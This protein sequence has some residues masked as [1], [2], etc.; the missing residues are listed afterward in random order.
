[1]SDQPCLNT[2]DE[3]R[4][5]PHFLRRVFKHL[6]PYDPGAYALSDI[7]EIFELLEAESGRRRAIF[8]YTGQMIRSIPSA[9][10]NTVYWGTLMIKHYFI[11]A[12][13]NFKRNRLTTALN[14]AGLSAAVGAAIVMYLFID[15]QLNMDEFHENVDDIYL[16]EYDVS[17][18]DDIQT[19][20]NS[21]LP[22]GPA[23]AASDPRVLDAVRLSSAPAA[24]RYSDTIHDE[25]IRFT[26]PEFFDVFSFPVIAG[27]ESSFRRGTGIV[28][29]EAIAIKYFGTQAAV[30]EDMY[31]TLSDGT[32]VSTTVSAVV[33]DVP[34]SSSFRFTILAPINMMTEVGVDFTD[35]ASFASAT[36]LHLAPGTDPVDVDISLQS[37]LQPMQLA[38]IDRTFERLTIEPLKEVPVRTGRLR[39]SPL[40]SMLP[41]AYVF[42]GILA[43]LVLLV[44]CFNYVNIAIATA[45][46]RS[47][48]IGIRKSVGSYRTQLIAQFLGENILLS[49]GALFVGVLLAEW[50][51]IPWLNSTQDGLSF[52][53]NYAENISLWVF[54]AMMLVITGLGAGMYPA[55][56]VSRFQPSEVLRG[57]T[58]ATNKRRM[59]RFMLSSQLIVSFMLLAFGSAMMRNAQHQKEID[60]GYGKEDRIIVPFG[61]S[62]GLKAFR[63]VIQ[64][65]ADIV[66]LASS[67]EHVGRGAQPAIFMFEAVEYEAEQL[68]IGYNYLKTMNI[69]LKEGRDFNNQ[70]GLDE[71]RSILINGAL[72]RQLELPESSSPVGLT[73]Q[74]ENED[75]EII[76]VTEDFY[77]AEFVFGIPPL[78][79]RI[80]PDESHRFLAIQTVPGMAAGT[81]SELQAVWK[82]TSPEL[83]FNAFYQDTVFDGYFAG[84]DSSAQIFLFIAF[85][86]LL[87]S[88]MGLF[89]LVLATVARRSVEIGVRKALG[90]SVWDIIAAMQKETARVALIALVIGAPLSYFV[91]TAIL[92]A[93]GSS[94]TRGSSSTSAFV[95]EIATLIVPI[96]IIG[97]AAFTT[98][99]AGAY[100]GAARKTADILRDSNS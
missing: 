70:R 22:L 21:P 19:W 78:M 88:V 10:N 24:L 99:F 44:A 60:W 100:R 68:G 71:G 47:R 42:F 6:L 56:F 52:N 18:G 30:G 91:I 31:M 83:P 86:A 63:N 35:W 26:D 54:L 25:R 92:R 5:P 93:V 49:L 89:G 23:I 69:G 27:S 17:V 79:L 32:I 80:T 76:G 13:R 61:N 57:V 98:S 3:S 41:S 14:L 20:G 43:L 45:I 33:E 73:L 51:F 67:S 75:L 90:A 81:F 58:V 12:L 77:N 1:M 95:M 72:A 66:E 11:A 7:D 46:R 62:P 84:L 16:V 8:W 40:A 64:D 36:F 37:Y 50:F 28:L 96:I 53:L 4:T 15:F 9:I 87:I 39:Q 65:R 97:L 29:T 74:I 85:I 48:E 94:A 2:H 38:G 55:L 34:M 82:Q 59:A